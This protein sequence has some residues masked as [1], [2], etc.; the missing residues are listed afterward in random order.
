MTPQ[1]KMILAGLG[2]ALVAGGVAAA[3]YGLGHGDGGHEHGE[4]TAADGGH[5]HHASSGKTL[6]TA[7]LQ[8]DAGKKWATDAGLRDAMSGIRADIEAAI[9]PIHGGTFTPA[10]YERLA[11]GIEGKVSAMVAACKL[12]PATDVQLHFVVA[13]LYGGA[14]AMKADGDRTVGAVKIIKALDA[15]GAHFDHPG[16]TKIPH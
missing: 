11:R 4:A 5:D 3:T 6:A 1:K 16:W 8:L 15:Y 13:D 9:P 14:S 2:L 7:Q 12:P 10:D